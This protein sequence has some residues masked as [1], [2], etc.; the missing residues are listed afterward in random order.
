[1]EQEQKEVIQNIYTT[2]GTTAGD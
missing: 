2:L 1:M